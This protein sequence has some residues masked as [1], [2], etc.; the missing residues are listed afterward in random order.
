[1][2][3]LLRVRKEIEDVIGLDTIDSVSISAKTGEN[4]EEILERIIQK[5]PAPQGD[6]DKPLKALLFDSWYDTYLGR[7]LF[8][9]NFRWQSEKGYE[10]SVHVQRKC[11]RDRAEWGC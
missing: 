11:F 3:T 5:I 6:K 10:N 1:M 2:P 9:S 7:S 8:G 4:V